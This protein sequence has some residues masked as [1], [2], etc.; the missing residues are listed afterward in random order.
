VS[1]RRF[2]ILGLGQI[3]TAIAQRLAPFGPV[4][5]SGPHAK[6]V[7]WPYHGDVVSLAHSSDVLVVACPANATTRHLVNTKV[8]EALGEKGYIVN[9]SR[10]A[11]VDESALASA[12]AE[13]RLAGAALDVFENEP[14]VPESLR[15]LTNTVLTPHVASATHET[16]RRMADLLLANL[17]AY[18]Q[19][20]PLPAT[21]F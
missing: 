2:G 1:G 3:G 12:L 8:I 21:P 15:S 16:R 7:P 5:W 4:S 6:T 13:G 19:G 10:G 18:L 14:N 17:D 9:I 11:V 20:K